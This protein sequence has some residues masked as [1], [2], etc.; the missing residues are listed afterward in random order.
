[1]AFA[2]ETSKRRSQR[3]LALFVQGSFRNTGPGQCEDCYALCIN[4]LW[5]LREVAAGRTG[6][7]DA[8]LSFGFAVLALVVLVFVGW[9]SE[10]GG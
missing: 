8:G 3:L 4:A 2:E 5:R 1:M 7:G 10:L 9:A 6:W